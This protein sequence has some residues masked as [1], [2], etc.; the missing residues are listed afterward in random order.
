MKLRL[1]ATDPD[2]VLLQLYRAYFPNFGFDVATAGDGLECVELLREFVPDALVLSLELRWGGADGVLSIVRDDTQ[3]QPIP[4]VL[5]VGDTSRSKA[6]KYLVPPV[7]KLLEKPFRLRDLR[8]IV[9]D[10]LHARADRLIA[11]IAG[12]G[13]TFARDGL[14]LVSDDTS[15]TARIN[16]QGAWHV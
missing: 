10:S 4:V 13:A 2:P 6:V 9:E 16:R 3:V 14:P 1:L 7:V 12:A 11:G 5:T 15:F 8:A